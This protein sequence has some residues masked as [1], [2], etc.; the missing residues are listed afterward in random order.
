MKSLKTKKKIC[1]SITAHVDAGK[2]TLGEAML[3]EAGE[4]KK[5]GRVDHRDSSLD[6][7][8]FERARG[9]TAFSKQAVFSF[10]NTDFSLIDTPGH[11]D[12]FAETR[13]GLKIPDAAVLV[14]SG[15]EGV[16]A[17]TGTIW[18]LLEKQRIPTWLFVS[19][20]DLAGSDREKIL[21]ELKEK[22]SDSVT[23][24]TETK[25]KISEKAAE[26]D[27][28]CMEEFL[29]KGA[30]SD[31]ALTNSVAERKI[32]PCFFGSGL[33][34]DG[35]REFLEGLDRWAMCPP[36]PENFSALCYKINRDA[37]G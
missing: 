26:L 27:E 21:E 15:S 29:E 2:T 23:D 8:D 14:I 25:G 24:F 33:K 34:L 35:V 6:F 5:R 31:E 4:L 12:L 7:E 9:I 1:L 16:Q 30:V 20:M 11:T 32:F 13:R 36:R 28:T 19:K 17:D 18:D 3:F 10:G 22:L 37:R